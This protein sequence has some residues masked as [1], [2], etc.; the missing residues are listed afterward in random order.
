MDFS[1]LDR[2][3]YKSIPLLDESDMKP[4][5]RSESF[6]IRKYKPSEQAHLHR[7]TYIQ[8]NYVYR[9]TGHHTVN[10]KSSEIRKGDIFVIPPF[11]PHAIAADGDGRLEIYEFE[12]SADFILQGPGD[13]KKAESYLDF[14][15]LE[16]FMVAEDKMKLRFNLDGGTEGE[17]E[18]IL[19]EVHRE[20]EEKSPGYTLISK[21]LLLKLLVITGRAF[22][23]DIKGTETERILN[24]YKESIIASARYIEKNFSSSLTLD[25][26]ASEAGYSKSH[27]CYLFKAVIGRTYVEYLSDVRIAEAKRLLRETEKSVTEISIEVGYNSIANFNKTFKATTGLS[28]LKYRKGES[29][30]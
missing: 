18:N 26:I 1:Y 14:A 30:K 29:Q 7:H 13:G 4:R 9:G 25:T 23:R 5:D 28:P 11:V 20:Y 24:R 19:C 15:Y 17:V 8:I 6:F 2:D 22:S 27:F 21:A 3:N 10:D 16:P 12:F